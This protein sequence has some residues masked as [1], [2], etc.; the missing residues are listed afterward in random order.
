LQIG[1]LDR[2]RLDART[3]QI[4][5]LGKLTEAVVGSAGFGD[6]FRNV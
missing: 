6:L 3:N 1:S 4:K 2:R 5:G